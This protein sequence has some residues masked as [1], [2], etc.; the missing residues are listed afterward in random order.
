MAG[1]ALAEALIALL[2][3][4]IALMGA[5]AAVI[6]ALAAQHAALLQSRAA[7]LASDLAETLR[8][9]PAPLAPTEFGS[10]QR[11]VLRELPFSSAEVQPAPPP[12]TSA[13]LQLPADLHILLRWRADRQ[14]TITELRLPVKL[15]APPGLT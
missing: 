14:G 8:G 6:E 3:L 15:D 12:H 5:G 4:A 13:S 1:F 2:L 7:D 11:D 9:T 10:W